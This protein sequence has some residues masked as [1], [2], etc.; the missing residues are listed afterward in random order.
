MP[1]RG[2]RASQ[3]EA[4]RAGRFCV[5]AF[6]LSVTPV[7]ARNKTSLERGAAVSLRLMNGPKNRFPVYR[8]RNRFWGR[9]HLGAI[10]TSSCPPRSRPPA[11][12]WGPPSR[13][14]ICVC[15]GREVAEGW[16][17]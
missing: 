6:R 5:V 15:Q 9:G 17:G 11:D 7:S 3:G 2:K 12:L 13:C 8:T 4:R 14:S 1:L 10:F 16:R